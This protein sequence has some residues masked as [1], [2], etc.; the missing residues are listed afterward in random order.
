MILELLV[1]GGPFA[2]CLPQKVCQPHITQ[3]E[4]NL[5]WKRNRLGH[6]G[7]EAFLALS[8]SDRC[9]DATSLVPGGTQ[10]KG[11]EHE[12][13]CHATLELKVFF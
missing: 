3:E 9:H 7:V 11:S 13:P 10:P 6:L 12:Q 1:P 4:T 8:T 2:L 5:R